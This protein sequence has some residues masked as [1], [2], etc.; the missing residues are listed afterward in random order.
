MATRC[1]RWP[2]ESDIR[3]SV[4]EYGY[5]PVCRCF[6]AFVS[7]LAALCLNRLLVRLSSDSSS[8]ITCAFSSSVG[9]S[10][11]PSVYMS[12]YMLG[13]VSVNAC[14]CVWLSDNFL[15][16]FNRRGLEGLI[17]TQH[18]QQIN[19]WTSADDLSVHHCRSIAVLH[20]VLFGQLLLS[21]LDYASLPLGSCLVRNTSNARS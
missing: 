10:C 19:E 12:G 14:S 13:C 18:Q 2:D 11:R 20:T 1:L 6:A 16:I 4:R 21:W 5:C 8:A 7:S 15:R 9:A 17:C 3:P